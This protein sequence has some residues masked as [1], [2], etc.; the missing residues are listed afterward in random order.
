MK[1]LVYISLFILLFAALGKGFGQ[2]YELEG[3]NI[4]GSWD[5]WNN[6]P[7]VSALAS[8]TQ[9]SGEVTLRSLGHYHT[10]I[11][12]ASSGGD[13][14]GGSYEFLFTS[15]NAT[16]GYYNNKWANT[17]VTLNTIQ[18][19][20]YNSGSNN[21]ITV[22]NGNYY[23]VNWEDNGYANTR[24]IFMETSAE[25]VSISSLTEPGTGD[26][27]IGSGVEITITTSATPCAEENI[28]L[29][30]TTDNWSTS[31]LVAFSFSGTTGT[32]TIPGQSNGTTVEYYAYSTTLAS[33]SIG[34]DHDLVTINLINN[35][36]SN[37]TYT[38]KPTTTQDGNF[39]STSTWASGSVPAAS[40]HLDINHL[41]TLDQ[42]YSASSVTINSGGELAFNST[43]TL[44]IEAGGSFTNDGTLTAGSGIF[45]LGNDVTTG[46]AETSTYNNVTISGTN[47]SFDNSVSEISGTLT[48]TTGSLSDAPKYLTGSTLRYE[49]GGTY[50]RVTE[51]NNPYHVEIDN[52]TDLH[53]NI[54]AF[55]GD[56][57]VRGNFT[58]ETGSTADMEATGNKLL[59]N[60]NLTLD[61]TLILSSSS[62]GDLTIDGNWTCTG[63]FTPN[64]RL[65]LFNGT[66]TLTGHTTFDYITVASGASLAMNDG[67]AVNESFVV[68]STAT[69]DM[70]AQI[71]DGTGSFTLNSG[72]TLKIGH[73]DGISSTAATGNVQVTGTRTFANDATYHY[74]GN[75]NQYSGDELPTTS[76]AKTIIIETAN[77]TDGF[78]INTGS[79][80][81]IAAGGKLKIISGKLI[82]A[83]AVSN[84]RHVDGAGDLEMTGGSYFFERDMATNVPRLTGTYSITGGQIILGA[85]GDQELQGGETYYDI[86][87]EGSGTAT[88]SSS[89]TN[90]NSVTISGS[91]IVDVESSSL[92]G[93]GTD[94]IM[95]NGTLRICKL[96][97]TQPT[98]EGTYTLSGGTIEFYGTSD[99]QNQTI[100]SGVSYNN[101]TINAS[102]ANMT[103]GNV[104][105][106]GGENITVAGTITVN[107]P[108]CIKLGTT[109]NSYIDGGTF[110]LQSGAALLFG[111]DI[112]SGTATGNI[113]TT[114]KTF[115]SDATYSM[116][117]NTNQTL[118]SPFPASVDEFT[119]NKSA[120]EITLGQDLEVTTTLTLTDG[121]I[122]CDGNTL[123][124]SSTSTAAISGES[125]SSYIV[126]TLVRGIAAA[127]KGS[128]G[129]VYNFPIGTATSY[130]PATVDFTTAPSGAGTLQ[131]EFS[132][133]LPA[134]YENGL[135][136]DDGTQTIDHLA[137]GGYWT[138]TPTSL[139]GYTYDLTIQGSDFVTM[140]PD[141]EIT[142]ASA[143][144]LLI[145]D[146]FSSLWQF[147]GTHSTGAASPPSVSRTGISQ[148]GVVAMGAK[149]SENVLPV[150]LLDFSAKEDMES[151]N[152][153]WSTA[154]E[155]N[156]DFF[157][158]YHS[159]DE[160]NFEPIKNIEGAGNSSQTR[161]YNYTAILRRAS[162]TIICNRQ[163]LMAQQH[164]AGLFQ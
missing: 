49:Q 132:T 60:G 52:N 153:E 77:N 160:I 111:N 143:L 46:G 116:Y 109:S 95:S 124:V 67:I 85:A 32:A 76:A 33:G 127:K 20:T 91:K 96:S 6:P 25:P 161:N 8:S 64:S 125:S 21:T 105:I 140:D 54:D 1:K 48:I 24:A 79:S 135:P 5:S 71:I 82:E 36:G 138:L 114:T 12:V 63:T 159:Y 81:A 80:V 28:F 108:A 115:A 94:L 51:W 106:F 34:T 150:E 88:T 156:N 101:V 163:I 40:S 19:Y 41:L 30:Y 134:E 66:S 18:S 86:V 93:P 104:S 31:S 27:V 98:M 97:G 139:A 148:F 133:T 144:R 29:R 152:L 147:L 61:G 120:G 47:V 128:K 42:N 118:N 119:V 84:G 162:T 145:R 131:A 2:I 92:G 17:A 53:L 56:L 129:V 35:G 100:R 154:T 112:T 113:R 68:E 55:G 11:G 65:V 7:T 158:V 110:E 23:T 58:I 13:I 130:N 89:I 45:Q 44:T 73:L 141:F 62:S 3:L 149:L 22:T 142:D 72:S 122:I 9:A 10:I 103:D 78:R 157:T 39:S 164:K 50:T 14:T 99:A 16:D 151:I 117:G 126:G 26:V 136:M 15:G 123:T 87:F 137:D 83:D 57:T 102:A 74:T 38:V 121:N 146:D 107:S 59:I 4:P 70:G 69:L 90:V 155:T 43:E 75:G 37:Y